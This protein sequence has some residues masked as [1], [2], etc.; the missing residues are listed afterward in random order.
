ME[1]VKGRIRNVEGNFAL[2]VTRLTETI[3]EIEALVDEVQENQKTKKD[4]K[5]AASEYT[6]LVDSDITL[7]TDMI[8]VPAA[9]NHYELWLRVRTK[10]YSRLIDPSS[11]IRTL[12]RLLGS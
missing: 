3:E 9:Q 2:I 11:A 6:A 8:L 12:P 1:I 10:K 5:E 4:N 7:Q